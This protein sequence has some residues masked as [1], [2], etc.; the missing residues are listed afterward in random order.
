MLLLPQA[1]HEGTLFGHGLVVAT[2]A[3]SAAQQQQ[4]W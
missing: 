4:Q 1:A 2:R 3:R